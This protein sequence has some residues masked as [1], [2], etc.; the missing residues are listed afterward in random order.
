M[1]ITKKEFKDAV[2]NI[3]VDVIKSTN[4]PMFTKEEKKKQI[5]ISQ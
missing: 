2:K 4:D 1:I 3:I 5:E